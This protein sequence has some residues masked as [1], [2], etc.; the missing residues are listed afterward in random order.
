MK[1]VSKIIQFAGSA[2]LIIALV[3]V[4]SAPTY[5]V[6]GATACTQV[7]ALSTSSATAIVSHLTTMDGDFTTRL[8]NISSREAKVDTTITAARVKQSTAFDG[9]I[10]N[11]EAKSDLTT[12]QL[13]AIKTYATS[14]KAAEQT[15]QKDVDTARAAYGTGLSASVA[16]HQTSLTN[17]ATAYQSAVAA[18]FAVAAT[19]CATQGATAIQTLKTDIKAARATF[20]AS[21]S[22]AKVTTDIKALMTTRN[23]A[24]AVAD[25][26]FTKAVASYSATLTAVLGNTTASTNT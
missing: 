23:A 24:I 9:K 4:S 8:S 1:T 14:I 17:A 18:A 11:L 3:A 6:D 2:S 5:A 26:T 10:T 20:K 22:D 21:R 7:A 25:A 19:N 16:T 13:A 12:G 15:R